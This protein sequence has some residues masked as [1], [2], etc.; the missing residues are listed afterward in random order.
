MAS[1]FEE[2]EIKVS[3]ALGDTLSGLESVKSTL[4]SFSNSA[5][6]SIA[7]NLDISKASAQIAS[8]QDAIEKTLSQQE[9]LGGNTGKTDCADCCVCPPPL[10]EDDSGKFG[11]KAGQAFADGFADAALKLV[12]VVGSG[13]QTLSSFISNQIST[14][15][16]KGIKF[17]KFQTVFKNIIGDGQLAKQTLEEIAQVAPAAFATPTLDKAAQKLLNYKVSAEQIAPTL[18]ILGDLSIGTGQSIDKFANIY[19]RAAASGTVTAATLN[20]LQKSSV[21]VLQTLSTQLGKSQKDIIDLAKSGK[22]G[23]DELQKALVTLTSEGGKFGG[24]IEAQA[25]T[26]GGKLLSIS[27]TFTQT[28]LKLFD[29]LKPAAGAVLDLLGGAFEGLASSGVFDGLQKEAES[30]AAELAGNE[31][32][33]RA[34]EE[35]LASAVSV[36]GDTAISAARA[37]TD[38]LKDNPQLIADLITGTSEFIQLLGT[39]LD[40]AIKLA[41]TIADAAGGVQ[42]ITTTGGTEG[43]AARRVAGDAGVSGTDFDQRLLQR[44][45]EKQINRFNPLDTDKAAAEAKALTQEIVDEASKAQRAIDKLPRAVVPKSRPQDREL[46]AVESEGGGAKSTK[47]L[48][49]EA[50][51]AAK[52]QEAAAKKQAAETKKANAVAVQEFAAQA[53]AKEALINQSESAQT[54]AITQQLAAR[55]TTQEQ[56]A[57]AI[58]GIQA[59]STQSQIAETQRQVDEIGKL[60]QSGVLTKADA[61]KRKASLSQESSKLAVKAAN[62]AIA[63]EKARQDVAIKAL[64]KRA[65]AEKLAIDAV[66]RSI[67]REKSQ[68]ENLNQVQEQGL[69]LAQSRNS[70]ANARSEAAIGST[71]IGLDTQS[72]ADE[73]RQ[74]LKAGGLDSES[75]KV[76]EQQASAGGFT[77]DTTDLQALEARQTL[78]NQLAQQKQQALAAEQQQT[79]ALLTIDLKRQEISAQLAVNESRIGE[80]RAKQ[81]ELEAKFALDKAQIQGDAQAVTIAQ[82]QV[83]LAKQVSDLS[84]ERTL[85]AREALSIQTELAANAKEELKTRQELA[86]A[87]A[88]SAESARG[89]AAALALAETKAKSLSGVQASSTGGTASNAQSQTTSSGPINFGS[90]ADSDLRRAQAGFNSAVSS[91]DPRAALL[92]QAGLQKDNAFFTQL[93]QQSGFGDIASQI[94]KSNQSGNIDSKLEA[95]T[96]AIASAPRSVNLTT[97]DP[98]GDVGRALYGESQSRARGRR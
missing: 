58:A 28:Q 15:F 37:L 86:T 11:G 67:E 70:L 10:D 64:E 73:A 84:Q 34:L 87:Q 51:K 85:Q 98:V 91:A 55:T 92:G 14:S 43:L 59:N 60:E 97:P 46:T 6:Q 2:L 8:L 89:Q 20:Q 29:S 94:A 61:E 9:K 38:A 96:N 48:E 77:K 93:L 24:L 63:V 21:P 27:N 82:S 17:E 79:A 16:D 66:V 40:I 23:F 4:S 49:K 18:A 13:I 88:K 52:A 65:T 22:L 32:L 80:A 45:E 1:G 7:I 5:A 25:N 19:G 95:L 57:L 71:Q 36:L 56:A 62:D 3:L 33:A 47:Q 12:D 26:I 90:K 53:Q 74:K 50:A 39:A 83:E 78:E 41:S 35:G 72:R 31:E 54:A 76:L 81:A 75:Q 42:S 44:L 68:L 30:F 69:K